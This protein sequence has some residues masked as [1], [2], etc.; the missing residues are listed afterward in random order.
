MQTLSKKGFSEILAKLEQELTKQLNKK[1]ASE[2]FRFANLHYGSSSRE[3]IAERRL[4][5]LYGATLEC[6]YFLQQRDA[7][8]P[9]V[10]VFNPDFEENGW[11][12]THTVIVILQEDM[13]FLID[14]IRMEVNR[15]E[16]TIHS[17]HNSIM[18]VKRDKKGE[19]LE[20]ADDLKA[21]DEKA[22]DKK[23]SADITKESIIYL[24]VDR[25]TDPKQ[26]QDLRGSLNEILDEVSLV[27][28]DF[29]SMRVKAAALTETVNSIA[30]KLSKVDCGEMV[31]FIRWLVSDHFTFLGYESYKAVT[32]GSKTSLVP[33]KGS[34]LGLFRSCDDVSLNLQI[35]ELPKGQRSKIKIS[36]LLGFSKSP[37]K[38][39]VH[40]PA[41]SDYIAFKCF[42][43]KGKLK[44]EHRF[45]GLYT[46]SVYYQSTRLI[47]VIRRKVDAVLNRSGLHRGSH[48]WKE[49]HQILEIYPR[50]DL[51]QI[52]TD[53]LFETAL[54]ILHIHERRQTR[55]FIRK[56]RYGR[57]YSCLVYA[58]RDIYS[59]DFRIRVQ[60]ILSQELN[61]SLVEF[62]THF[63]ESILARTQFIFHVDDLAESVEIDVKSIEHRVKQAARSWQDELYDA[64]IEFHGEEQGISLASRFRTGFSASYREDFSPRTAVADIQ[65]LKDLNDE[66]RLAMSFYREL[67]QPA[68]QVNFKLFHYGIPIPLSDVIPVMENLG[69]KV[70]DEHPYSVRSGE[71]RYW[72]H[73][74]RMLHQSG[75]EIDMHS[76]RDTFQQ[77]FAHIWTGDAE[78]DHFNRL[79]LCAQLGWREVAMLRAY[80]KYIKQLKF[81]ISQL[82]IANCLIQHIG[83]TKKLVELFYARFH[84]DGTNLHQ[85]EAL[86]EAIITDLDAVPSLTD[87]RIIRRYLDLML[88]SLRTN[89]FQT[90]RQD[91]PKAYF[92]FKFSP[93]DIPDI[94]QPRPMFEIFV[95]SPRV[96]GVHLRG[97]KVARGGLRWSDRDEDFRTEVLGLVKAQQV[98]NAVIVPVGAKGGF[99]AR[100]LRDDM[101]REEFMAEGIE[102]YK[103]FIR[104]LLDIT[105]NLKEDEVIPPGD[106]IRHDED[107]SYLVVAADKGT[108]TF[109][110][111]ANG[112]ANE[113]GFWLGDAFASGGSQG[114]DHKGMGITARGAWV[115]VERHFREFDHDTATTDFSVLA[116]GD[117][118]GDVFGNGMLRSEH[119]CLVAAFNH[120]H[121]FIDPNPDSATS[122]KERERLFE[123]PR[124]SW[125]DYDQSLISKG[126]GVFS[127]A[128]KSIAISDE[129]RARFDLHVD[130]MTP[131]Q[132]LHALLQSPVDLI[133]NGGI[134]TYVKHSLETHGDVGD[135]ANDAIRVDADQL[136]CRVIG[137]GGNLGVT[138]RA[139][140]EFCLHG[141][142]CNTDF[143]DNAGGVDCS[144]HE[145][146]I[147][148]LLDAIVSAGDLTEKQRNN[149]LRKM[150]EDVSTLVLDNNYR[151][152]QAISLAQAQTLDRM[153]EFRRLIGYLEEHA[154]LDRK[155]EFIP[156]DEELQE[157][158][159]DNKGFTRAELSVVISYC[160]AQLKEELVD[161]ELPED[162]YIARELE[163]AFPQILIKRYKD[164][165]YN[166]RLRRE[167]I[168]TQIAN[169]MINQMGISY[170]HRLQ[171]S[172]GNKAPAIAQAYILARDAFDLESLWQQ[173][174]ALDNQV[175]SDVQM[176]MMMELQRLVRR[177]S[178]W[179]LRNRRMELNTRKE[180][181]HFG[182]QIRT[183][184]ENMGEWL[185]G[186]PG[187]AWRDRYYYY[188]Q[189]GVPDELAKSVAGTDSLYM[190]LGVI[191][192]ASETGADLESV[193][194]A[195][196]VLGERLD[197]YW[198]AK[199]VNALSVDNQWQ[200]L[201]REAF[202]DDLDWQVRALATSLIQRWN[203]KESMSDC[204][205]RWMQQ[206][207]LMVLRWLDMLADLKNADKQDYSMFTVAIRELFDLAKG[208][209]LHKDT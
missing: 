79:V 54:G 5:E 17:I 50:D 139:R 195:Y 147:K 124:S 184:R 68:E 118:A 131:N 39:R 12:S 200:A 133:W 203:Q 72:I 143:I 121:I 140:M 92:S 190:S 30:D 151:Q 202:R 191:E 168:S 136:R 193:I 125:M 158:R 60:T 117:M 197:M 73:D 164:D 186:S 169:H 76:V 155:L 61:T 196:C 1:Q 14:S 15:R 166:H 201:A 149:L 11:Q 82:A 100:K 3:E 59:T 172:T 167:I 18:L 46:S 127:R 106:V 45:L 48:D 113:Y 78:S 40:R 7:G 135:K 51:F 70:M 123:L 62:S 67:E 116:V 23:S 176:K 161:S 29:H 105:D 37:S 132:L 90:D 4:E 66:Q 53:E 74:F 208:S 31:D 41:Y 28:E 55:V 83:I 148:I 98:K 102:C 154:K 42:D 128:A 152:A 146:N 157:R 114:Y 173:I 2:I 35:T 9:K 94:P 205:D 8:Q 26:L 180:V 65:H 101:S 75:S 170:V 198:F 156:E 20:I 16:L 91:K 174:E 24:E 188:Q 165:L 33:V 107:D 32:K 163:T 142:A 13:P 63:S 99:I 58:P 108:A 199:E 137:E 44:G 47:P 97:G 115:S 88:A 189:S 87:D 81:G 119:I 178:R 6:W 71:E 134:G 34:E 209:T 19:L 104:G 206:Y 159:S 27:T 109:S 86:K 145:V 129:M 89:F 85:Q 52:Q 141:G 207:D 69:L 64:L 49:L 36:E 130:K 56:D 153:G 22:G 111:I 182:P 192:V 80:A 25:H 171:L 122:F 126:G 112:I 93:Q 43:D 179:F 120:M 204:F 103:L 110:D 185:E 144:D 21:D 187:Q 77:A 57:Y 181:E 150:T 177:A 95:Y 183:L 10:K 84:P 175:T 38:S 138:Q 96:Q 162:D 160:K 194:K